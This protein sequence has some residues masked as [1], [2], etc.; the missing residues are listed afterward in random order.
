MRLPSLISSVIVALLLQERHDVY[1]KC[2]SPYFTETDP[3]AILIFRDRFRPEFLRRHQQKPKCNQTNYTKQTLPLPQR[4][5]QRSHS[6]HNSG[7]STAAQN[8]SVNERKAGLAV[9]IAPVMSCGY[10]VSSDI[11]AGFN[12][13]WRNRQREWIRRKGRAGICSGAVGI[14]CSG[15]KFASTPNCE[16]CPE[17]FV[18]VDT[19]TAT[20]REEREGGRERA[21]GLNCLKG[22][23]R[24]EEGIALSR[25]RDV[26]DQYKKP[27]ALWSGWLPL[28]SSSLHVL[29]RL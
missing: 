4:E 17:L 13:R 22:V 18:G 23:Q 8:G 1:T 20:Q 6:V 5:A 21:V 11:G 3:T 9:V 15:S 14:M 25:R 27:S 10:H 28:M 7:H 12:L 26:Y 19:A 29:P 16:T 24:P 2:C